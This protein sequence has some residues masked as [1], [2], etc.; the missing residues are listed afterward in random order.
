MNRKEAQQ[1]IKALDLRERVIDYLA[2][3][4]GMR[5]G[6]ILALLRKHVSEDCS[7]VII[8]QRLYRGDIDT[9]KTI[10][11]RRIVAIPAQTAIEL[12]Q[13]LLLVGTSPDSWVFASENPDNPSGGITFGTGT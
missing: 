11:S 4:A 5:P 13:W 6:E 8:E 10:S 7:A 2:L 1:H 9:P 3:F 12:Q